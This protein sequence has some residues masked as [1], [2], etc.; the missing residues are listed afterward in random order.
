MSLLDRQVLKVCLDNEVYGK[1]SGMVNKDFFP[2]DLSTIV[3][4][5]HFCQDKYK[6]DISVD[7]LLIA[8][9]EKFPALPESTRTKIEAEINKLKD[10]V[11]N[12]EI[13]EDIV[14]SFWKRT[15]AKQVGEE[16]LEIYLGKKNDIGVL[17]RNV[18]ELKDN[19]KNFSE[20]YSIIDA[21]VDELI[22]RATAPSD[23]KFGGRIVDHVAGINRGNFGI[24]FARPEIGKTTFSCWLSSEYIR[25]G[26][27]VVY[28]AN[29]EPAIRVKL[30]IVQSFFNMN[31]HE[32]KEN[33]DTVRP[34]FEKDL[35]PYITVGESV[36][37][38]I[39]EIDDYVS[40]NPVDIAFM[41]QLDKVRIDGEFT[42]GD[43]RLKELYCRTREI[44]KH[45]DIATWAVSQA[46]F[47]AE[48]RHEIN[49][50]ML[51]NSR[52]GKAG[53]ADII[54]GI[55][56]AEDEEFRT[57]KFSKNK[58]NGWHGSMVMMLDQERGTYI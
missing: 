52:T 25:N 41:D 8:H 58:I 30:R 29:E 55:G 11:T 42:R 16:A 10:I 3:D 46:S 2:R 4:T 18:E 23:F 35:K 48:G 12:P 45:N 24:I 44:A 7:D 53:E 21:G 19:E 37:T 31:M 5:V 43:E 51:D 27:N 50:S 54:V 56:L 36:G 38:S 26:H 13:V 6:T 20:T 47:E 32:L 1:I 40:R 22:E 17:Y 39:R 9:R 28:W 33:I 15:K 34:V 14:H 57:I 49:Y